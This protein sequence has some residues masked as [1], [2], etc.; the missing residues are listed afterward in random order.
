[1]RALVLVPFIAFVTST[2]LGA[3]ADMPALRWSRP[4]QATEG[5]SRVEL[6]DDVVAACRPGLPDLRVRSGAGTEVPFV[7]DE[8]GGD[9]PT[10]RWTARDVESLPGRETTAIVDRGDHPSLATEATIEVDAAEFLKPAVV[11]ASDDAHDWREIARGS[12][13]AT[14]GIAWAARMTTLRFA[15]NDRRYWRL[16]LDDRNGSPIA[17]RSVATE[18]VPPI[19][20]IPRRVPLDVR[21]T[22]SEGGKTS[23]EL[24]LPSANLTVGSLDF[25]PADAVFSRRVTVSERVLFRDEI[26]RRV[27]ASAMISRGPGEE[28]LSVPLGAL[29]GPSLEIEI[30]DGSSPPLGITQATAT[31]VPRSVLFHA[32]ASSLPV[33]LDYGSSSLAAGRYDLG[34]VLRRGRPEAVKVASLGAAVDRGATSPLG[35]PPHGGV[36]DDSHWQTKAAIDLPGDAGTG[37]VAYLPLDGIDVRSGLRIVDRTSHEVPFVFERAVHH[38]RELVTPSIAESAG[39]TTVT[40]SNLASVR[41][42]DAIEL[43]ATAPDYFQRTVT[44]VEGVR[45]ARGPTGERALG[46][47]TWERRPGEPASPM[48]IGISSPSQAS[49]EVRIDNG[50]NPP[51]TLGNATIE[52]SVRRIDFIFGPGDSLSLLAGNPSAPAPSYDLALLAGALLALPA[53]AA[54]VE[55]ARELAPAQGGPPKWFWVAVIVA[56]LG[57]GATLARGLGVKGK[58]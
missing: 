34:D 19:A 57:V 18:A 24:T 37:G 7:L 49:I 53:Q 28:S 52:R 26:T 36:L 44:V 31:V 8:G 56:G 32:P 12:I 10:R 38:A 16:R 9:G 33:S 20:P 11:E 2:A 35:I 55:P 25:A 13:F 48:R 14:S 54:H 5:W 1:M 27:V 22:A 40:L 4:I 45:D 58:G 43:T 15:P 47:G 46:G 41:E 17:P 6:P 21:R 30:E 50:G 23:Y 42:I 29:R 3:R 51:L 39:R